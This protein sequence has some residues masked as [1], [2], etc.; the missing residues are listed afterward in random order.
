M[1]RAHA[2]ETLLVWR[3]AASFWEKYAPTIRAMFAPVTRALIEEAGIK[4]GQSVLDVAGGPGEPSLAIAEV[5]A[6]GGSVTCT[7]A[8]ARMVAAAEREA[9]R[10]GV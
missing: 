9:S 5:V 6:P 2:E 8:V 7:D 10:R 4:R 1:S 3:D